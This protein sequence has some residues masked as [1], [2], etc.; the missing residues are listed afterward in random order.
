MVL[1][2]DWVGGLID[3]DKMGGHGFE[4]V[5]DNINAFIYKGLCLANVWQE[6]T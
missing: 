5:F 2:V 3:A 4:K 6:A 1:G